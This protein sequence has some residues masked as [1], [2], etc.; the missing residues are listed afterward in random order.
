M[1]GF[2]AVVFLNEVIGQNPSNFVYISGSWGLDDEHNTL[3]FDINGGFTVILP[4]WGA[5]RMK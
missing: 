3:V 4:H 5:N 2:D 1:R